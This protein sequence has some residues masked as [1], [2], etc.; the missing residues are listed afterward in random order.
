M[1]LFASSNLP[2]NHRLSNA[3]DTPTL[4]EMVTKAIEILSQN[5]KG[6]FLFVEGGRIDHALHDTKPFLALDETA[7]F[8]RAVDVGVKMIN[9]DETLVVA[10]ADHSHTMSF[11][12]YPVSFRI[13]GLISLE[14]K[15]S[16]FSF[17]SNN[18]FNISVFP[19]SLGPW[20]KCV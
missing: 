7:E 14:I 4:S 13:A 9:L 17:T 20:I 5:P 12:G 10:T 8:A 3:A 18:L 1:G 6:F 16:I 2:Y 19:S 15:D 11:S